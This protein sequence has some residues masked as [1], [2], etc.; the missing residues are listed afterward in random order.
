MF[1]L[2]YLQYDPFAYLA[3][4]GT[5]S[6]GFEEARNTFDIYEFREIDWYALEDKDGSTLYIGRPDEIPDTGLLVIQYLDGTEA[7]H[8]ADR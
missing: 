6:G 3:Q 5:R 1:F 8:I 4:G 2:F 7:I